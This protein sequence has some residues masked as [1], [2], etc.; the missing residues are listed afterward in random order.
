MTEVK[1][2]KTEGKGKRRGSIWD[3]GMSASLI[4]LL[5]RLP[6]ANM[7][8]NEGNGYLAISWELY[9]LVSMFFGYGL[10]L[11]TKDMVGRRVKK[12]LY[13]NSV[14]VFTVSLLMGI[15]FSTVGGVGIY[16]GADFLFE[17]ILLIKAGA[18]S[19]KVFSIFLLFSVLCGC[20][21]GYFEGMGTSVPTCYSKIVEALVAGG[22]ALLLGAYFENYGGKIADL[23]FIPSYRAGFG[24]AGVGLGFVCG[25][26]LSLLFLGIIHKL[27]QIPFQEYLK[28][29]ETR[30]F[31]QYTGLVKEMF[32]GL[33]IAVTPIFFFKTYRLVNIILYLISFP[34]EERINGVKNIG[35]Y[36]GRVLLILFL[37]I[38]LILGFSNH[39]VS[40]MRKAYAVQ[41]LKTVRRYYIEDIKKIT[42]FS[43]P[44]AVILGLTAEFVMKF[45][46]D[47]VQKYE[48]RMLQAGCICIILIP[49]ATYGF[50][51]LS[52][53]NKNA[54]ILVVFTFAFMV[55]TVGMIILLKTAF[56]AYSIILAEIIFWTVT[57]LLQ[58]LYFI[59]DLEFYNDRKTSVMY[60][61]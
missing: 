3:M 27:Y 34:L 38:T 18:I 22:T 48:V 12:G 55:Q 39:N 40:R 10:Y 54:Q 45:F 33:F 17:Q 13:H 50:Y 37:G 29:D 35:S 44:A 36:Y 20:V 5:F 19:F 15:I 8:G 43:V 59:K 51:L 21:R 53:C 23:L 6:L 9:I 25:A 16:F 52:A 26:F 4:L 1:V 42:V 56:C 49:L 2:R 30:V 32:K 60:K 61:S 28:K 14:R 24:A 41:K 11:V 7:I 31:E 46:F 58:S 47:T 57:L